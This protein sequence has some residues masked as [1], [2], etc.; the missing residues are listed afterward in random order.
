[1]CLFGERLLNC[2]TR[3]KW[4]SSASP[5][6]NHPAA[7][8]PSQERVCVGDRGHGSKGGSLLVAEGPA[9][10]GRGSDGNRLEMMSFKISHLGSSLVA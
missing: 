5:D 1:M 6:W 2:G 7:R 10:Q 8:G 9:R 3:S 4:P